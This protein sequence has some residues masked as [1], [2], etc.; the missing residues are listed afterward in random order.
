M[1]EA[2][3]RVAHRGGARVVDTVAR[4]SVRREMYSDPCF[5]GW[6]GVYLH[7]PEVHCSAHA[8]ALSRFRVRR[9]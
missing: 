4:S 7:F 5:R 1:A 3:G 6:R 9:A 2:A 8:N